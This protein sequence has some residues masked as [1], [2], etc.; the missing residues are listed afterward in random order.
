MRIFCVARPEGVISVATVKCK[1]KKRGEP[2]H[3]WNDGEKDRIYCLGWLD[4]MTDSPLPECLACPDHV[5]K[6]EWDRQKFYDEEE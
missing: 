3:E 4:P 1:L 6:A 2:T 5:D